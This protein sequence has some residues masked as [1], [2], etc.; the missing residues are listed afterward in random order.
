[1]NE[2]E[3]V[4]CKKFACKRVVCVCARVA[5]CVCV[6]ESG[7]PKLRGGEQGGTFDSRKDVN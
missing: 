1:M 6:R 3:R 4:V 7:P 2:C 5:S